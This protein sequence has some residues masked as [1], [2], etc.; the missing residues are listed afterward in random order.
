[1]DSSCKRGIGAYANGSTRGSGV[2]SNL[3]MEQFTVKAT[4][5][6][7]GPPIVGEPQ[8]L[9]TPPRLQKRGLKRYPW[10]LRG[11]YVERSMMYLVAS[12]NIERGDELILPY[13]DASV[14]R[15]Q[16]STVPAVC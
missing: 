3:K 5:R 2:R 1:M 9:A 4:E 10:A 16:H 14:L 15:N 13:R 11:L 12:R 8:M 6:F 7:G